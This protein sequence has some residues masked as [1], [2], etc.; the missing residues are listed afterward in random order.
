MRKRFLALLALLGVLGGCT[1]PSV[2]QSK[3]GLTI[4]A[5]TYPIYLFANAVTQGVEGI[6]VERLNTGSVSCLHDY[7]LSVSDMKKIEKADVI[8]LNGA[9]LEE[10]MEDALAHSDASVIDCS[11]GLEL[12]ENPSH[13]HVEHGEEEGNLSGHDEHGHDHG[14]WDPHYWMHPMYG[15][16]MLSRLRERMCAIDPEHKQIYNENAADASGQL[17]QLDMELSS[18]FDTLQ[19]QGIH[20]PGLITFHDGFQYFA[21]AYDLPLLE[22]IEEEAGSE[23]SAKEIVEITALVKEH[24]IP[25]IFT[26]VNG[27]AATANAISRET[28]CLVAQL[29]MCMD[30]PDASLDNYLNAMRANAAAI[31]NGFAEEEMI[32]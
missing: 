6:T 13:H 30:G 7:T 32:P 25:V 28:G 5:T 29:S 19:E 27:S 1:A 21:H 8:V 2:P 9:G 11:E 17:G 12:L 3:D 31:V 15:D 16:Y 14:H 26:E 4:V 18:L 22:S 24:N 10:F 23:A 20:S